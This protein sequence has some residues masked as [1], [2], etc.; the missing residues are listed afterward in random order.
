MQTLFFEKVLFYKLFNLYIYIYIYIYNIW[1]I[2][3]YKITSHIT[4]YSFY[5]TFNSFYLTHASIKQYHLLLT[6]VQNFISN[7]GYN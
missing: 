3:K 7:F 1:F 5:C 2:I 6:K 4:V